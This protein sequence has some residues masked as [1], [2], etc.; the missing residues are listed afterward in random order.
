MA[1]NANSMN[2]YNRMLT[3]FQ[4]VTFVCSL[5]GIRLPNGGFDG[6]AAKFCRRLILKFCNTIGGK[7]DVPNAFSE[8]K[9]LKPEKLVALGSCGPRGRALSPGL[10]CSKRLSRAKRV[11]STGA[12]GSMASGICDRGRT[13]L[14]QQLLL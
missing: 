14:N 9:K 6:R 13:D 10:E 11:C 2:E 3:V 4:P 5:Q 8:P 12:H 7:S 1:R